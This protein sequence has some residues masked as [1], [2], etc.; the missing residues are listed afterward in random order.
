MTF[1]KDNLFNYTNSLFPATCSYLEDFIVDNAIDALESHVTHYC[2]QINGVEMLYKRF[3]YF[4][5]VN[6]LYRMRKMIEKMS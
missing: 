4:T 3:I 5:F 6:K 1:Y 2:H